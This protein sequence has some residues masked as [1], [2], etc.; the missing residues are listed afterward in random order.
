MLI[1]FQPAMPWHSHMMLMQ[2]RD[3][4]GYAVGP[5]G[6]SRKAPVR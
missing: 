5:S 6:G 1:S 3:Q 4:D 2:S